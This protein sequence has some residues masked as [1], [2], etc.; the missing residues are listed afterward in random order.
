[1]TEYFSDLIITEEA[2]IPAMRM[3]HESEIVNYITRTHKISEDELEEAYVSI[4]A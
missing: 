1:M 3:S 2:V 4:F